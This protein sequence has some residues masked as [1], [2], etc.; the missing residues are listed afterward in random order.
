[1]TRHKL[2]F[3]VLATVATT[4]VL[5]SCSSSTDTAP[6][7]SPHTST[8]SD[9]A[10][11]IPT[12]RP[13]GGLQAGI[14]HHT[15]GV[16]DYK[17]IHVDKYTDPQEDNTVDLRSGGFVAG[18]FAR[19]QQNFASGYGDPTDHTGVKI[20]WIPLHA[21][22]MPGLTV[23]AT[24]ISGTKITRTMHQNNVAWGSDGRLFYPSGVPIPQPGT[25]KLV[26]AAG[27]DKGCFI[28]TFTAPH[29]QG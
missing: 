11:A 26:A 12:Q 8:P 10:K 7:R 4:I 25:W 23:H 3:V 20:Y 15:P 18:D 17:C 2:P 1:M 5:G 19:S 22:H 14:F 29:D 28:V 24:R 6:S 21:K 16:A 27:Q 9:P 13:E